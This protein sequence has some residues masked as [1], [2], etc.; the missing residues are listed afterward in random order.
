MGGFRVLISP[1]KL[2]LR[3]LLLQGSTQTAVQPG[4][5]S[6]R[7]WHFQ[8]CSFINGRAEENP[9]T[10]QQDK[11]ILAFPLQV[12]AAANKLLTPATKLITK[13]VH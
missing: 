4:E 2:E 8:T 1:P 11:K 3:A 6:D 12:L 9:K 10:K 7:G 13:R 5:Q